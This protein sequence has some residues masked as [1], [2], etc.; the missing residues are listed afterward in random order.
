MSV[1]IF[2]FPTGAWAWPFVFFDAM[3]KERH[4]WN[5]GAV[6]VAESFAQSSV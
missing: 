6:K 1:L 4:S 2:S 5:D 3:V